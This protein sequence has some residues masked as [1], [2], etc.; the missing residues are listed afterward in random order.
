MK[1]SSGNRGIPAGNPIAN[2]FVVLVGAL[3]IGVSVVLGFV[4]FVVLGSIIAVL[5]AA[6]GLRLWWFNRK[7]RGKTPR[8]AGAQEPAPGGVIE[9]EFQ[10][11]EDDRDDRRDV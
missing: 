8:G 3:V 10:V 4:A 7:L 9:G 1:Y 11:I 5:A 6:I 2:I